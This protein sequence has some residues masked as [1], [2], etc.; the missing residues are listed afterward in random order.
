MNLI[1]NIEKFNFTEDDFLAGYDALPLGAHI[2]VA[3][4]LRETNILLGAG[5][6]REDRKVKLKN[7]YQE[8]TLNLLD[9]TA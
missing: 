8:I 6:N 1:D 2:Y 7:R 3:D 4:L 5:I 9:A